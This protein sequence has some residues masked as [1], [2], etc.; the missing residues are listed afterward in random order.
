MGY[1]ILGR[2]ATVFQTKFTNNTATNEIT[3]RSIYLLRTTS[4]VFCRTPVCNFLTACG[5]NAGNGEWL[6]VKTEVPFPI[7]S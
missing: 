4:V 7:S 3:E 5:V 2:Q 6:I 1:T